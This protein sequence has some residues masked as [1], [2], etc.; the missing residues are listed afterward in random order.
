ME[1]VTKE[2]LI[3]TS[4]EMNKKMEEL[5]HTVMVVTGKSEEELLD[6]IQKDFPTFIEKIKA[7]DMDF[8]GIS[9]LNK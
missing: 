4:T 5:L 9:N 1:N 2:Q 3:Q 8:M 6:E 7:G